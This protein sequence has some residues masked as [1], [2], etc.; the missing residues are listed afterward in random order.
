MALLFDRYSGYGS[1]GIVC[2]AYA[3]STWSVRGSYA[4]RTQRITWLRLG[5]FLRRSFSCGF[6]GGFDRLFEDFLVSSDSRIVRESPPVPRLAQP[7]WKPSNLGCPRVP[8][9]LAHPGWCPCQPRQELLCSAASPGQPFFL[10]YMVYA[11]CSLSSSGALVRLPWGTRGL[12]W[13][14]LNKEFSF[15]EQ[16][17]SWSRSC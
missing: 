12:L 6:L 3:G 7:G 13:V 2:R 8:A 17:R 15:R 9:S 11:S 4:E 14:T 5:R 1:K 16:A 10:D